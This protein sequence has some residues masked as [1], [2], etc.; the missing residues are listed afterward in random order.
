MFNWDF[1]KKYGITKAEKYDVPATDGI[2][3]NKCGEHVSDHG[4]KNGL[5]L[6]PNYLLEVGR[7]Y[8]SEV[9]K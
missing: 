8:S 7:E 2:H 5:L 9:Q 6:H 1:Y 4:T 3:C